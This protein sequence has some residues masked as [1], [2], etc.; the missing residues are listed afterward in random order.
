MR[1][2]DLYNLEEDDELDTEIDVPAELDE[3]E[4]FS[5]FAASDEE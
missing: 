1:D 3:E 5:D 2:L 4:D